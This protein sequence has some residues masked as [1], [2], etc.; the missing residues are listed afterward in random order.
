[1][2]VELKMRCNHDHNNGH[3]RAPLADVENTRCGCSWAGGGGGNVKEKA[4]AQTGRNELGLLGMDCK[5]EAMVT[6]ANI[7]DPANNSYSLLGM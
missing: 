3:A 6:V 2:T 4:H 7:S 5:Q 1:M